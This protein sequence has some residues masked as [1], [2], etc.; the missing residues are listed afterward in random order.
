MRTRSRGRTARVWALLAVVAMFSSMLAV[1]GTTAT[2]AVGDFTLT[3]LHNNDGESQLISASG[4][5]DYGGVARFKTLVDTEKA[6][7]TNVIMLSSG[8]NFLAGP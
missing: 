2:A 4:E 5:P 7:A 3:I 1:V 6:A 8:D